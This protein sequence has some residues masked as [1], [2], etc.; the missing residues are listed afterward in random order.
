M[1]PWMLSGLGSYDFDLP[2]YFF[3]HLSGSTIYLELAQ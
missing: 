1:L 2:S 3:L